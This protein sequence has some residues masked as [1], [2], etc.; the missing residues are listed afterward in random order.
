MTYHPIASV[1]PFISDHAI[2]KG[3]LGEKEEIRHMEQ[4]NGYTVV[5]YLVSGE[6]TFDNPY[7]IECRGL[8]FDKAGKLVARPLHKFFNLNERASSRPEDFDWS[9]LSRVMDK[10]DGSMIH[11]VK[12]PL[13][14]GMAVAH[15][16]DTCF[17]LK[18]KKSF[19][20]DVAV[21]ARA[22][23]SVRQNFINFCTYITELNCTA[24]FEW[25]SPTARIVLP[26]RE[27]GLTLLHVRDNATGRYWLPGE[28]MQRAEAH[29]IPI[30]ASNSVRA[31]QQALFKRLL[32]EMLSGV[33]NPKQ[34]LSSVLQLQETMTDIEGWVFQFEDGQMV[35]VK[36]KWY[37]ERH[38]AM[39]FLRERDIVASV[40]N[41]SLDDLKAMLV[42]EGVNI[43]EIIAL[44]ERTV[45]EIRNIEAQLD[46]AY[47]I[48]KDMTKKEAALKFGPAGEKFTLFGLLMNK[49]DGREPDIKGWYERNKLPAIPLRQLNLLQSVAEAE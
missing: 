2:F 29:E 44:E 32:S 23:M 42:G 31:E 40:L 20:S 26:Y 43:S 39:T 3:L 25:T 18:S 14:E 22:W 37:M 1:F 45:Q 28:L 34:I 9:K 10:R 27:D 8:V 13:G 15:G 38:R 47:L 17:T 4:P 12:T 21:Q 30:V 36:T 33:G 7:A 46:A 49:M 48:A 6:S 19:E 35:K 5:S 41:E 24:I 16:Y 11:T